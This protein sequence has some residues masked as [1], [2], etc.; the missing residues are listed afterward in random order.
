MT[1]WRNGYAG[2]VQRP[3]SPV[4]IR[5]GVSRRWLAQDQQTG[6][7][8]PVRGI[9]ASFGS[10]PVAAL[11]RVLHRLLT[12]LVV[13]PSDIIPARAAEGARQT[14]QAPTVTYKLTLARPRAAGSRREHAER[15]SAR[16]FEPGLSSERPLRRKSQLSLA[17]E[18]ARPRWSGADISSRIVRRTLHTV[19]QEKAVGECRNVL[20]VRQP[21]TTPLVCGYPRS[22]G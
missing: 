3:A 7:R 4:R 1:P 22:V 18:P 21:E 17:P 20:A 5:G 9:P 12:S 11:R 14:V 15:G 2:A 6:A 8:R 16:P 19:G 13:R 10:M